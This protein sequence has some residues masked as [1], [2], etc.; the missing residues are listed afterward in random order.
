[1]M[2]FLEIN[3]I[4]LGLNQFFVHLL[5]PISNKIDAPMHQKRVGATHVKICLGAWMPSLLKAMQYD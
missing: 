4:C 1:M 3:A 2:L 5:K